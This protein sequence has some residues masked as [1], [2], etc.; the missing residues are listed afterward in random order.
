MIS[1]LLKSKLKY[2]ELTRVFFSLSTICILSRLLDEED[3]FKKISSFLLR[4]KIIN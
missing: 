1:Q 2:I 4:P 3:I